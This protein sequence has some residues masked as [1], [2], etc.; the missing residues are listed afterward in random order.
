MELVFVG[1]FEYEC[2]LLLRQVEGEFGSKKAQERRSNSER[3]QDLFVLT[4]TILLPCL[5]GL[6]KQDILSTGQHCQ[7]PLEIPRMD[8]SLLRRHKV[9]GISVSLLP[10]LPFTILNVVLAS[11]GSLSLPIWWELS[12]LGWLFRIVL[13]V[14][15]R[16]AVVQFKR[17]LFVQRVLLEPMPIQLL[18]LCNNFTNIIAINAYPRS[19]STAYFDHRLRTD[20]YGLVLG[21][22]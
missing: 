20:V 5:L 6:P 21:I 13:I 14:I 4:Y 1:L 2:E 22:R 3:R 12:L 19:L 8:L 15:V 16:S 9:V 17:R 18:L 11:E 10:V 7:F